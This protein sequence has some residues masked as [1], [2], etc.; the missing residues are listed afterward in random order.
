MVKW[1]CC[2]GFFFTQEMKGAA[3]WEKI[4]KEKSLGKDSV[5]E[6]KM[7]CIML[8]A[9]II[10]VSVE[11]AAS[12][13]CQKPKIGGKNSSIYAYTPKAEL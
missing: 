3:T 2:V 5:N 6:K 4:L 12:R 11:N 1:I 7:A 8:V 10:A 9:E 13:P